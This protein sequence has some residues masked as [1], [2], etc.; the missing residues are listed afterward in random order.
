MANRTIEAILRLSSRLGN[1]QAFSR[2]SSEFDKIDRKAKAYNRSQSAIVATAGRVRTAML[3]YAAP[4]AITAGA[5][6]ATRSF[7]SIERRMNR[8]GITADA[9]AEETEAALERVRSIANDV[10]APVQGVVDALDGMVAAGATMQ[11]ALDLLPSVA[12]AAQAA[13]ADFL[14]M[15]TTADAIANSFNIAAGEMER[16]FDIVAKGGKEGKFELKDMA[17]YLP[18]LAPAFAALGY[19]GEAGLRRL[20]AMLQTVRRETG[21]SGEAATAFM[22][23]LTKMESQTVANNFAKRFGVDLREELQAAR[24]AGEDIL[25]AFIRLSE[26]AVN[27]DLAKLPQLFTDKQMLIAMRA[28]LRNKDAIKEYEAAMSDAAGTVSRD[29]ERIKSDTQSAMDEMGNAWRTLKEDFGKSIAPTAVAAMKGASN[30]LT[31]DRAIRNS[32]Y[33]QNASLMERMTFTFHKSA[34]E[35]DAIARSGGYVIPGDEALAKQDPAMYRAT[36]FAAMPPRLPAAPPSS[37][38]SGPSGGL[39][40]R[41]AVQPGYLGMNV[42]AGAESKIFGSRA[43][44]DLA[45][46]TSDDLYSATASSAKDAADKVEQGIADGGNRAAEAITRSGSRAGDA[47]AMTIEGAAARFGA[48]AAESF[49]SRLSGFAGGASGQNVSGVPGR[50][51]PNAGEPQSAGGM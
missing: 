23:V 4:A 14:D 31:K 6:A 1:M 3:A 10:Q 50:T 49:K 30:A 32:T 40:E 48:L 9:S 46:T 47:F 39:A 18:S 36:A 34:A 38:Y 16:A 2:V 41:A 27:G 20:A 13:D 43:T 24:D 5:T 25:D 44:P 19:D 22:D 17:S 11:E 28:I 33:W 35:R 15:A 12:S 8:I 26:E 7:A 45:H 29:L 42:L 21:T 51:M 37:L